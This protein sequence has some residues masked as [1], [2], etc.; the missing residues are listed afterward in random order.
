MPSP[1]IISAGPRHSL[2]AQGRAQRLQPLASRTVKSSLGENSFRQRLLDYL[3]QNAYVAERSL[4]ENDTVLGQQSSSRAARMLDSWLKAGRQSP[5][6]DLL[7]ASQSEAGSGDDDFDSESEDFVYMPKAQYDLPESKPDWVRH[8]VSPVVSKESRPAATFSPKSKIE[9]R[10]GT[11]G[12]RLE[13]FPSGTSL[14]KD[15]VGRVKEIISTDGSRLEFYY[16]KNGHLNSFVRIDSKGRIISR[17]ESDKHGVLVRDAMGRVKAQGESMQVDPF[18]CVSIAREDGQFWSL[19][20]VRSVHIERRLLADEYGRWVSM[21]ALFSVDGFR[22][23][24]RFSPVGKVASEQPRIQTG[25]GSYRFYGRDGSV[26]GFDSDSDLEQLRPSGVLPPGTKSV[27][28]KHWGRR[29]AGTA[30]ESLREY[31]GNYLA[32]L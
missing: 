25:S 4:L 7:T 6:G 16:D 18:G 32:A 5:S 17:A 10:Q 27:V 15:A 20:L 19:D 23:A 26:I 28:D 8:Q 22:M 1:P 30:W 31:V 3:S 12:E 13:T 11:S 24:T 9:I 2:R 21:T 29:Q 14:V